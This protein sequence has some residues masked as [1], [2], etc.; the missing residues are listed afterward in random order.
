MPLPVIDP[1]APWQEEYRRVIQELIPALESGLGSNLHSIYLYGSVARKCAVPGKSNLDLVVVTRR[2]PDARFQTLLS[3][4]KWRYKKA[5]PLITD[6]SF[7]FPLVKDILAIE[8]VITWGF[9][10]KHCCV[11]V[12]G[13][14]LSTRYGEFEPSW[15]I[16]KFWNMDVDEWI[17]T[18][19]RR[20]A[21]ATNR[22]EQI[23]CQVIIAK[24]LLRASYSVIMN[25][26]KGWYDDPSECGEKFLNYYPDKH[27]DI[28][29]LNILLSGRYIPKRSIIGIL[30]SYGSWLV[31]SYKKTEFRIG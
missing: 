10:L 14:D 26:D 9:M 22:E 11:C 25:K 29:R 12:S 13:D 8:S 27:I 30:D 19:R 28:E 18:Y 1:S 2:Q 16:A 3:T 15:E 6:L 7:Q 17:A 4:I 20:I 31:K 5:F 21:Q 24:K 23:K